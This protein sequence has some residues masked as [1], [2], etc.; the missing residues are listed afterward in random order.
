MII[1]MLAFLTPRPA[2]AR[3]PTAEIVTLGLLLVLL[4]W[5]K[6]SYFVVGG[7]AAVL[8]A[9]RGQVSWRTLAIGAGVCGGG[10]LVAGL[11]R[12]TSSPTP[13]TL[14][15]PTMS[16]RP[17]SSWSRTPRPRSGTSTRP[18][19]MPTM[20]SASRPPTG[21]AG[22]TGKR[23]G[24]RWQASRLSPLRFAENLYFRGGLRLEGFQNRD[25]RGFCCEKRRKP[26]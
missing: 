16:W 24:Q 11:R 23:A 14:C 1:A 12:A 20:V 5:L 15:W 13:Q 6:L 19:S 17:G 4:V 10:I 7:A 9:F 21:P 18:I 22:H 26:L 25:F 2:E 3:T 8:Y